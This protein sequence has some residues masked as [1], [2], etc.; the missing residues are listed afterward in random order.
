MHKK[1]WSNFHTVAVT[2]FW[3]FHSFSYTR[4]RIRSMYQNKLCA[5]RGPFDIRTTSIRPLLF[6]LGLAASF[7][8]ASRRTSSEV[9]YSDLLSRKRSLTLHSNQLYVRFIILL[10]LRTYSKG[11]V[12][13]LR[14]T[15]FFWVLVSNSYFFLIFFFFQFTKNL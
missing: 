8:E 11:C 13:F 6:R 2:F 9:V 12:P 1:K 15:N 3:G 4:D 5:E 14:A 7:L 10:N